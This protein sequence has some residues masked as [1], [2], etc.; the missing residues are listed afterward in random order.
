MSTE[1][2]VREATDRVDEEMTSE[3]SVETP[4]DR[5]TRFKF[6][7]M[8]RM[9]TRFKE[10]DRIMM[11]RVH[12]VV[13][14][15]I[16][17]KFQDLI[18]LTYHILS[19]VRVMRRNEDGSVVPDENGY[20]TWERTETGSFIEDWSVFRGR[21]REKYIFQISTNIIEWDRLSTEAWAE[22]MFAK[23]RWR[24][25]FSDGYISFK[26]DGKRDRIEDREAAA[27]LAASEDYYFAILASY[28][29]RMAE[30]LVRDVRELGQ[31]LKD[32]HMA[33]SGRV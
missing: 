32:V 4:G 28:Y 12:K 19:Q 5:E 18:D 22:A 7:G 21:E 29:S 23:A 24:E 16:E 14:Q 27:T 30:N 25:E 2:D 33:A 26:A 17:A 15:Q 11:I 3:L 6:R 10:D 1:K 13:R 31:R 20:P 8:A 9:P